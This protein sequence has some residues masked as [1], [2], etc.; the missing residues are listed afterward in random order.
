M[1]N[2]A[3]K[4]T[5]LAGGDVGEFREITI[6]HEQAKVFGVQYASILENL[7]RASSPDAKAPIETF[8]FS[9]VY[10]YRITDSAEMLLEHRIVDL[11]LQAKNGRISKTGSFYFGIPDELLPYL[12]Y[13]RKELNR[14]VGGYTLPHIKRLIREETEAHHQEAFNAVGLNRRT[15]LEGIPV[16]MTITYHDGTKKEYTIGNPRKL[17]GLIEEAKEIEAKAA[18]EKA[19]V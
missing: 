8:K 9:I 5:I 13:T 18:A 1:A 10:Y 4:T 7:K 15:M 12:G 6:T 3:V 2:K 19:D 16:S 17:L 14:P 11:C